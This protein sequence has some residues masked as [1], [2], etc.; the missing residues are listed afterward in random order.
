MGLLFQITVSNHT[1]FFT[2]SRQ[3][4]GTIKVERPNGARFTFLQSEFTRISD[5]QIRLY[6]ETEIAPASQRLIYNDDLLRADALISD[7]NFTDVCTIYFLL[8]RC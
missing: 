4:A 3:L 1:L 5:L 2:L 7:Y 6:L 8:A